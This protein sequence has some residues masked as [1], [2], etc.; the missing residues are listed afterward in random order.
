L[1]N[2]RQVLLLMAE[3][4]K[5]KSKG[6]AALKAGMDPRTARKYRLSGKLPSASQPVHDW[7]TRPDPF[8]EDWPEVVA[9]LELTPALKPYVLFEYLQAQHPG[10]H[11]P[12]EIRTLQRRIGVW[13]AQHGPELEVFFPQDHRPGAASQT[14]FTNCDELLVTILGEAL[15]HLLCHFVLPYSNWQWVTVCKSESLLALR[16]GM[17]AALFRLGHVPEW[18]QTDNSTA[19]THDL[20]KGQERLV[21]DDAASSQGRDFNVEYEAVVRHLGMKPRTIG[22]GKSEQN[23][24]VESANGV[25]KRRLEQHLLLRG[26][27]DFASVQDYERWAQDVCVTANLSRGKRVAEELAVMKVLTAQRLAECVTEAVPVSIWSTVRVRENTYSVP[28]RLM[29]RTVEARVFDDRVEIWFAGRQEVN[30]DRLLGRGGARINYRHIIWSLMRKPGAFAGYRYRE[31]L[32]PTLIFR[33]AYDALAAATGVE[34]RA[35]VSYVRILHHAA[36]TMQIEVEAALELLL[37]AGEV[38][39]PERVKALTDRNTQPARVTEMPPL[40]PD[41]HT[42]DGLLSADMLR[43]ETGT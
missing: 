43:K 26:S 33:R 1:V 42:Y 4:S 14:D 41:L 8:A 9:L 35:D 40:V 25:L 38:P 2:D 28:S 13:K 37:D 31:E 20:P 29:G 24:D 34:R 11:E 23:G 27:R 18:A 39:T 10:R 21:S 22:V 6:V 32:F 30:V 36:S 12:G 3:L 16:R 15:A 17:Q 5:S 19:A 7:R